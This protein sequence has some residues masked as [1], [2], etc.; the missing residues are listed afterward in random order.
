MTLY[1]NS[2]Q[3]QLLVEKSNVRNLTFSVPTSKAQTY[4]IQDYKYLH[5]TGTVIT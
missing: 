2:F 5:N 4:N 1:L 3:E